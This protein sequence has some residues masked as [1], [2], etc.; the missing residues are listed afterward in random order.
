M[1]GGEPLLQVA[2]LVKEFPVRNSGFFNKVVAQVQAVSDVTFDVARGE[3]LGLVGQSGTGKSPT[4]PSQI[5]L[6]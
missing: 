1:T 3:T 5:R 4:R 6:H 2:N